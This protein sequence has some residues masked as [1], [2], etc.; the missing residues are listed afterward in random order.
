LVQI[1]REISSFGLY[2]APTAIRSLM[3]AAMKS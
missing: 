1:Y 2:S 3:K